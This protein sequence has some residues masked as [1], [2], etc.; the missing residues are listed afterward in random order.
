MERRR[1]YVLAALAL[2][3]AVLS[4]V[5]LRAVLATVFFAITV[6]YV[7][8]PLQRWLRRRG[9]SPR[10]A[11]G[12]CTLVAFL[13]VLAILAPLA[14]ALYFRRWELFAFLRDLPGEL[15]LEVGEFAVTV[16]IDG[17]LAAARET[18][19]DLA[20]ATAAALPELALQLFLFTLLVYALLLKPGTLRGALLRPVPDGYQDVV[21]AL[22]E[23]TRTTLYAL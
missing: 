10:L 14:A 13:A 19:T 4:V 12:A 9:L 2:A 1:Q 17:L 7:A 20:L 8:Y 5:L 23:R 11:A 21:L 6:A 18:A 22:H 15:P 3:L 16:D